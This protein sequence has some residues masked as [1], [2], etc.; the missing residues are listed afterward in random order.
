MKTFE[1][2]LKS[3]CEAPDFEVEIKAETKEEALK[4]IKN[5]YGSQLADF[6]DEILLENISQIKL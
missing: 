4:E 1:L 6:S 5:Q 2:Y 3:H